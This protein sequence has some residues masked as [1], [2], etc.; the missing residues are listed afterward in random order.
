MISIESAAEVIGPA[1]MATRPTARRGSQCRAKIRDTPVSAPAAMASSAP[2][3]INSSAAWKVS[4]T[5]TGSSG[6]DASAVAA[7]STIA[8]CASC[9]QAWATPGSV[10]VRRPGPFGHRQRVH[11]GP[12]CDPR[13]VLRSEIAD[14]SGA[15]GQRLRVQAGVDQPVG[16]V[17]GGGELLPPQLGMAVEVA[18]P[19]DEVVVVG[20]RPR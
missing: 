2:P 11:I 5:P 18:A 12:Q 6:T 9:P 3:G 1:V 15:A 14:Q 7:P 17:L 16:D 19:P 13:R 10:E 4:R 20:G 8:V